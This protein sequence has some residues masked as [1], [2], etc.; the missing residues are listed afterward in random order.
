MI[1][2]NQRLKMR[3]WRAPAINHTSK[4]ALSL[5]TEPNPRNRRPQSNDAD[6][7]G[8]PRAVDDASHPNKKLRIHATR[9]RHGHCTLPRAFPAPAA[10]PNRRQCPFR[11]RLSPP[12]HNVAL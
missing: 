3:S 1:D 12:Y 10:G 2:D 11:Q 6:F 8:R 7:V 5:T 9:G 4:E